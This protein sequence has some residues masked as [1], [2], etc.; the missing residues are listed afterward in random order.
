MVGWGNTQ[1]IYPRQYRFLTGLWGEEKIHHGE[2]RPGATS[3]RV[4]AVASARSVFGGAAIEP[5]H[6]F[7]ACCK[8]APYS[9]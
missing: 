3:K 6:G 4:A 9:S 8:M 7:R 1:K 5:D 2:I